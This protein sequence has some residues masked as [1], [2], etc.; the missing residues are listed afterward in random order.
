MNNILDKFLKISLTYGLIILLVLQIIIFAS[1]N[2]NFLSTINLFIVLQAVAVVSILALGVTA[3]LVVDGFDL[4]IGATASSSM[5]LSAYVMVVWEMS[6]LSAIAICLLFGLIVGITNGL[7]IVK[8]K[9]PDLLATLGIMFLLAGLQRIPTGGRSIAVGTILPNGTT[10]QGKFT[11]FFLSIAR[12]KVFEV[13]PNSVI[14]MIL[15]AICIWIFMEFTKWGRVMY[16]VGGNEQAAKLAGANV[17]N[18]KITAYAISG[19]YASIGGIIMSSRVGRGDIGSGG[20]LLLDSVAAALI[21][22]AFLGLGRAN[23]FGTAVGAIFIGLL[24]NGLTLLNT[25]YYTQ[26]FIKGVV[27]VLALII[28]FGL[29]NKK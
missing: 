22:F 20:S 13:I 18:F 26:D 4:S 12:G 3:T 17:N 8:M 1:A 9:I 5:M 2:E 28:T 7:L 21:G 23:P 11:D 24:L 15:L 16:A 14:I 25:P 10:A 29:K 27:L 6:G 19:V